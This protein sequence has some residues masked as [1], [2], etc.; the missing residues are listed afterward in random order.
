M[1]YLVFVFVMNIVLNNITIQQYHEI[2]TTSEAQQ[3]CRG[4]EMVRYRNVR[5]GKATDGSV[6]SAMVGSYQPCCCWRFSCFVI[7]LFFC[8]WFE[9]EHSTGYNANG[10]TAMRALLKSHC[11][12]QL[13]RLL[14]PM[15]LQ[16]RSPRQVGGEKRTLLR[17]HPRMAPI[18]VAV[19]PLV[20]NKPELMAKARGIYE[21]IQLRHSAFWDVS[22]AIGEGRR[23]EET[24]PLKGG[25]R[26]VR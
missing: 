11:C 26:Q 23:G 18:K 12:N 17:F 3:Q 7:E 22:G 19:F 16:P 1:R 13:P 2:V 4:V 25:K 20:K 24:T 5:K 8:F 14:S 10:M 15:S 21:S 6:V 9:K